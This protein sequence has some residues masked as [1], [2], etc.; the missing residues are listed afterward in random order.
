M[1]LK[2]LLKHVIRAYH[3]VSFFHLRSM[4]RRLRNTSVSL[5][6]PNCMGGLLLHDLGLPFRSPTVN[7]MMR[8]PDFVKL[9]RNLDFYLAREFSFLEQPGDA[10]PCAK[11]GDIT[12]HFTHYAGPEEAVEKWKARTER[13]DRSNLFVVL[14]E[15]DGLT[16]EEILSLKDLPVRGLLVFTANDYPEVP[17][18]LRV[19]V[20]DEAGEVGNLLAVSPWDGLRGY[21]RYFDFVRWFNESNGENGF[22]ITPYTRGSAA[23]RQRRHP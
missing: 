5:L 20:V 14:Q 1:G 12:I 9:V 18:A 15:R 11:L 10:C 22:D 19:P 8:Q 7:L 13:L 3:P 23:V 4:R 17:Y 2:N 21:E 16:G 6:C